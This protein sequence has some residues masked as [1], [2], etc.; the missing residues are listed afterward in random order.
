MA[1]QTWATLR[2]LRAASAQDDLSG[3]F[4]GMSSS[5]SRRSFASLAIRRLGLLVRSG[6]GIS[7]DHV[8]CV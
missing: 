4:V 6:L 5:I 3:S 7:V 1:M 8:G 2:S